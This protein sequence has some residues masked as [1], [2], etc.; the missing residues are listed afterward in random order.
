[1]ELQKMSASS[2]DVEDGIELFASTVVS[3][4]VTDSVKI[5]TTKNMVIPV[6]V[7]HCIAILQEI[8]NEVLANDG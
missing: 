7:K 2:G 6:D 5:G 3:C 1:M 4:S 8:V